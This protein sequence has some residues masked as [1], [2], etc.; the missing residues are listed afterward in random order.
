MAISRGSVAVLKWVLIVC[1]LLTILQL[2]MLFSDAVIFDVGAEAGNEPP[3][4]SDTAEVLHYPSTLVPS[5]PLCPTKCSKILGQNGTWIQDWN[6]SA[7]HGQYPPTRRLI[8][9][10]PWARGSHGSFQPSEDAPFPWPTSFRWVDSNSLDEGCQIDHTMTAATFCHVLLKLDIGSVLFSG[11]S[12]TRSMRASLLNMMGNE[13]AQIVINKGLTGVMGYLTC[14]DSSSAGDGVKSIPIFQ[15]D[16]TGGSEFRYKPRRNITFDNVT[17]D[18][19]QSS[20]NRVLAIYNMGAHYH[21]MDWYTHDFELFL[22]WLEQHHRPHDLV[23]FRTTPPGHLNCE[24]QQP[25]KFDFKRG[26]R[27]YPLASVAD[28]QKT[29]HYDW[30]LFQEYNAHSLKRTQERSKKMNVP[31]HMLD[32]YNMTLLRRDG[33]AGGPDC[34][35]Y[36]EPGPVDWWNHLLFTHLK[37]LSAAEECVAID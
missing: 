32:V 29:D 14:K 35:H 25:K 19:I 9:L 26:T 1:A 8:P 37:E 11:D 17:R 18:H 27:E 3:R 13:S 4:K 34:L 15:Q 31:I 30:N 12:M 16:A 5:K 33:H 6:Y 23:F 21:G 28:Y 20:P 10:G 22:E 36:T 24:P 2:S 7:T